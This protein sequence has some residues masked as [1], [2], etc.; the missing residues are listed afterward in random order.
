MTWYSAD[1]HGII[2]IWIYVT[3]RQSKARRSNSLIQASKGFLGTFLG[4]NL[5]STFEWKLSVDFISVWH[6]VTMERV[7]PGRLWE[8]SFRACICKNSEGPG[9]IWF[10]IGWWWGLLCQLNQ[11]RRFWI[12]HMN[13]NHH[14][15]FRVPINHYASLS[16]VSSDGFRRCLETVSFLIV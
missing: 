5:K 7:A 8:R 16:S 1:W 10:A 11:H 9:K 14:Q 3:K 15:P 13:I 6:K 2:L 12:I 4:N